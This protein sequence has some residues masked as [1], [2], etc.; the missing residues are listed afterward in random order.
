MATVTFYTALHAVDMI[1]ADKGQQFSGH[2]ERNAWV[3]S[4][5]PPQVWTHYSVLYQLSRL[6]R[7][8]CTGFEKSGHPPTRPSAKDVKREAVGVHLNAVENWVLECL[9]TGKKLPPGAPSRV[10]PALVP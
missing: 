2:S 6:V 5:L 9:A 4:N 10:P 3:Q 7:Y 1:S 8:D